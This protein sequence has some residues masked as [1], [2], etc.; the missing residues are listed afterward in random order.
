VQ[1]LIFLK[2]FFPLF[3][4]PKNPLFSPACTIPHDKIVLTN[5]PNEQGELLKLIAGGDEIAF[6]QL[7]DLYAGK[8]YTLAITYLKSPTTAQD[9]VQEVFIKVWEKRSKLHEVKN[10]P[11]YLHVMTRNLL[12]DHLQKKIPVYNEHNWTDNTLTEDRHLPHQQLD[13]RELTILIRQA[14]DQLPPRQQ[15]IYRLSR[16]QHLTHQQI[17]RELGLSYDTV[18]EHMSKALR[19][20]RAILEKYY[21]QFCLVFCW[22][23]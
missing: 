5:L 17:A 22:F 8:I 12:I 4:S 15:Q 1:S 10:F 21:G 14:V 2:I 6:R 7:Y 9:I 13:Y 18:R 3:N 19:N 20:I 16:D 11:A 23:L